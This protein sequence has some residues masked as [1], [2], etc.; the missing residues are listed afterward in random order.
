MFNLK[1]LLSEIKEF[2]NLLKEILKELIRIKSYLK[3]I[4][5]KSE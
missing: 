3:R 2:K 4:E 1:L 5:D